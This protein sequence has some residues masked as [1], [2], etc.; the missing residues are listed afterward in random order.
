MRRDT[1]QAR[2]APLPAAR[3]TF[4]RRCD[5]LLRLGD[6]TFRGF[7]VGLETFPD[8]FAEFA[9][10]LFLFGAHPPCPRAHAASTK[11]P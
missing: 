11:I 7:V 6:L 3:E 1:W 4:L 9:L 2:L 10:D 5:G 8:E